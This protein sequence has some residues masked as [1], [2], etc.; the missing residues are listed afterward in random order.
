VLDLLRSHSVELAIAGSLRTYRVLID[1]RDSVRARALLRS[2][3]VI[4][5]ALTK[6][7]SLAVP[8]PTPE[9]SLRFFDEA[10]RR[11]NPSS[12]DVE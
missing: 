12:A 11:A 5:P 9:D 1:E 3:P 8:E 2:D 4:G 10:Y 6:D 7:D